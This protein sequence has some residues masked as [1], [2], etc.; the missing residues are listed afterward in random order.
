V[1][2]TLTISLIC[3]KEPNK[4]A[5]MEKLKTKKWD[6]QKKWSSHKV[7]GV[8]PEAR[9]G[10]YGGKDLWKKQVGLEP[11]VKE[12]GSYGWW[13][14]WVNKV[15]REGMVGAWTGKSDTEG[16]RWGWRRELGSWFQRQGETYW[17]KRSVIHNVDDVGGRARVT[18]DEER[19]LQGG[20]TE[21]RYEKQHSGRNESTW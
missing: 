1:H 12:R 14:C 2:Q 9:K 19:V 6:A 4:K 15:R 20:W 11:G 10:V 18:R 8:S 21:I 5:V 3:R 17:K 7:R 16:L 13:E